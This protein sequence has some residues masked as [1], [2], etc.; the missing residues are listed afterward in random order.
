M[1]A[2]PQQMPDKIVPVRNHW[3]EESLVSVVLDLRY[4]KSRA[5]LSNM[6][7]SLKISQKISIECEILD[8][9]TRVK[10]TALMEVATKPMVRCW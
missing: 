10:T 4:R 5:Y 6:I 1:P 7:D 2:E 8:H 3:P 9:K